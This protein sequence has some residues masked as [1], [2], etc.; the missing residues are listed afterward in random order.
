MTVHWGGELSALKVWW[1]ACGLCYENISLK[2]PQKKYCRKKSG[3]DLKVSRDS[4]K[5]T[6]QK[7]KTGNSSG[8][9]EV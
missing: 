4:R 5:A 8:S 7:G 9:M 3:K 1:L 2:E 6:R